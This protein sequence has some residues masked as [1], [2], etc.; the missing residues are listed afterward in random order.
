MI[1]TVLENYE[2]VL[3]A[4]LLIS[5]GLSQAPKLKQNSILDVIKDSAKKILEITKKMKEDKSE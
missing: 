3:T 2:W 4:L 5:E 1:E